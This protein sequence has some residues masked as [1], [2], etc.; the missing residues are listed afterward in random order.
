MLHKFEFWLQLSVIIYPISKKA[1]QDA[2]T[3]AKPKGI[4][5]GQPADAQVDEEGKWIEPASG[6]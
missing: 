6:D 2:I 1:I 5:E 4:D 3:S